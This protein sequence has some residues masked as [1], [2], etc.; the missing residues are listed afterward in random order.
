MN[1]KPK[2]SVVV[3]TYNR[4]GIINRT[5]QS[6]LDQSLQEFEL[7]IVDDGSTDNTR[8]VV[9]SFRDSRIR[10]IVQEASGGPAKPRNRG[11][12]EAQSEWICFLDSDDLFLP[13][14]L[15][16]VHETIG[17]Y[18]E[19]SVFCHNLVEQGAGGRPG[20]LM[21]AGLIPHATYKQ[22]LL[23]GNPL[24]LSAVTV[25]KSFLTRNAILFNERRDLGSCADYELWLQCARHG[26][27]FLFMDAVLGVY[28]RE[29]DSMTM[30]AGSHWKAHQKI[31][32]HHCFEVQTFTRRRRMLYWRASAQLQLGLASIC[33]RNK[34]YSK[35]LWVLFSCMARNPTVLLNFFRIRRLQAAAGE[36]VP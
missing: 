4:A 25:S 16:R 27:R 11:I 19:A 17:K 12:E 20:R 5:I 36:R 30:D 29:L 35:L 33:F 22:M 6:V 34:N 2:F 7:I 3:P 28:W 15:A 8:R 21:L 1:A 18:P 14:K 13:D 26:A 23:G 32:W 9:E 31:L 24:F 10:Y